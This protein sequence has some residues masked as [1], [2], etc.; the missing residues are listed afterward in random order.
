MTRAAP[1]RPPVHDLVG[2]P[3]QADFLVAGQSAITETVRSVCASRR[4]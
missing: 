3:K 1:R 2:S 4:R